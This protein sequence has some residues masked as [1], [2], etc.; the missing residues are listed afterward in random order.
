MKRENMSRMKLK[1]FQE[2][3]KPP[4]PAKARVAIR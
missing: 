2:M 1:A 3:Y 4:T